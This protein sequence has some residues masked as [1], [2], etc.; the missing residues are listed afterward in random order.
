MRFLQQHQ[1]WRTR[2]ARDVA[3]WSI[4]KVGLL[5]LLWSLFFSDSHQCRVD[6][7]ATASRLGIADHSGGNLLARTL[8]GERCD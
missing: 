4:V 2:L 6:G 8:G 5:T 7:T 1:S 3:W